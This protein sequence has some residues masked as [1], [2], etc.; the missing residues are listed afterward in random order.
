MLTELTLTSSQLI[1]L[2]DWE[3]FNLPGVPVANFELDM[4][5]GQIY[6]IQVVGAAIQPGAIS[7]EVIQP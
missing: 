2:D 1:A 6:S 5:T 7:G 4:I 3:F